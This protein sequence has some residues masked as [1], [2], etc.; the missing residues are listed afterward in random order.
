[1]QT[2]EEVTLTRQ[3]LAKVRRGIW[4]AKMGVCGLAWGFFSVNEFTK[5]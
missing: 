4:Q 5:E 3:I 1:M 2:T